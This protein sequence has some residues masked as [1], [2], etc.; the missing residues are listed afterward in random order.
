M[1]DGAN[2]SAKSLRLERRADKVFFTG[3]DIAEPTAVRIVWARPISGRGGEI[4]FLDEQKREVLMLKNLDGVA[5]ASQ[6]IVEEELAKRYMIPRITR[7]LRTRAIFGIRYWDV[8][9]DRGARHFAIKQASKNVFWM[10]QNYLLLRDTLGCL[11]EIP[12]YAALD[13]RSRAEVQRVV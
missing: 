4:S 5:P 1:S 7:V 10:T 2:D 6:K 12:D 3:G 9:T 8:E 11:Y 13:D